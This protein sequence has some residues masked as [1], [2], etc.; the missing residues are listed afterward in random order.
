MRRLGTLLTALLLAT[1]AAAG[2]GDNIKWERSKK[3]EYVSPEEDPAGLSDDRYKVGLRYTVSWHPYTHNQ[4]YSVDVTYYSWELFAAGI[5]VRRNLGQCTGAA[6]EKKVATER[7]LHCKYLTFD[8]VI[9][10]RHRSFYYESGEGYWRFYLLHEGEE[11]EPINVQYSA[12]PPDSW[13]FHPYF[14]QFI[15]ADCLH[16]THAFKAVFENPCWNRAE[17]KAK[18]PPYIKVV[19]AGEEA[20]RGFEWR[21][22][23]D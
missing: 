11:L 10:V 8:V 19:V 20:T 12:C 6:Y 15:P 17:K 4:I 22:K 7:T 16:Y 3:L 2:A 9:V 23:Q 13:Y 21:F 1:A 14:I 18:A 5:N